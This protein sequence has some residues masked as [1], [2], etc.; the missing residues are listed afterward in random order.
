MAKKKGK[1]RVKTVNG[2][3]ENPV[4][5]INAANSMMGVM[6]RVLEPRLTELPFLKMFSFVIEPRKIRGAV[7]REEGTMWIEFRRH[8]SCVASVAETAMEIYRT[9]ISGC[10]KNGAAGKEKND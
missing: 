6:M 5:R 4:R 10:E 3:R 2:E 8:P 9:I 7:G 1:G